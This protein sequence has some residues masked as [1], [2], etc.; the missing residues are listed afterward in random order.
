VTRKAGLF[1]LVFILG[2]VLLPRLAVAAGSPQPNLASADWSVSAPHNL[3]KDSP[4]NEA[5]WNFMTHFWSD[6][7]VEQGKLCSFRFVD[8]RHSGEL[9]LVSVYDWGGTLDCNQLTI[10]DK[11]SA[12]MEAYDYRGALASTDVN[13]VKDINGD[14]HFELVV[15]NRLAALGEDLDW[16]DEWPSV[17]AWTGGGYTNV[18]SQYPRYYRTWLASLKKEIAKLEEE[19]DRLAQATPIPNGIVIA[20][21]WQSESAPAPP[22]SVYPV[23]PER[24]EAPSVSPEVETSS[25]LDVDYK[26]AQAAK[27]ER[28]LGSKEAGMLDA[29]RWANSDDSEV[30]TLATQVFADIGTSEALRYEQ[31]LSHDADPKVAKLASRN[32]RHWGEHDA[33]YAPIFGR[34]TSD[35][36]RN[37]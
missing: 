2:C 11:T 6:A 14:G 15:F 1:I 36:P 29:I 25:R 9:S 5:V 28:F 18:S 31:T 27:I 30:R 3:A 13:V 21:P 7:W 8:L 23:Q 24:P 34:V 26:Q 16:P 37:F 12:G 17:Y 10:F 35:H 32:V 20:I 19:R 4:S 33:Y 22:P